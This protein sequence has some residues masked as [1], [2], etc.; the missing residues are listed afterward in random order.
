M[1]AMAVDIHSVNLL[2][3]AQMS[4]ADL[5]SILTLGHLGLFL[6]EH[7]LRRF[8]RDTGRPTDRTEIEALRGDGF[9]EGCLLGRAEVAP[10][11][12]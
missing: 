4:G 9:C 1:R 3:L 2:R 11:R 12:P 10:P 7:E 8:C 5:S 6:D